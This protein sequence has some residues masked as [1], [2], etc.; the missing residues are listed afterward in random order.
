VNAVNKLGCL[1]AVVV[2]TA[3]IGHAALQD[4]V[5]SEELAAPQGIEHITG[6]TPVVQTYPQV[7]LGFE[8][9]EGQTSP[10][11]RFLARGLDYKL[12]LVP[13]ET[14]L[15]L[16]DFD[17]KPAAGAP[18]TCS[19]QKDRTETTGTSL[20]LK[21]VGANPNV[22]ITGIDKI[23]AVSNYFIGNNPNGWHAAVPH[24]AKVSYRS[25]YPDIDVVYYGHEGALD[26]DFL[27]GPGADPWNIVIQV[28]GTDRLSIDTE[29]NLTMAVAGGEVRLHQPH[30]YQERDGRR[31]P[32]KGHYRLMGNQRVGFALANYDT[33]RPL[34][35]DPVLTFST[36]IGGIGREVGLA[37]T[38]YAGSVYVAGQTRSADFPLKNAQ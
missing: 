12:F 31:E 9:N 37:V 26:Y 11:I 17:G 20:R 38:S 21:L 18:L 2:C 32:V 29:G 10:I 28:E 22:E 33:H 36:Y 8:P 5:P 24:Y 1:V 16:R 27:V 25:I 7:P 13:D 34:A 19:R 6:K 3:A 4:Y 14:V 15:T 35:I 30:V 23:P